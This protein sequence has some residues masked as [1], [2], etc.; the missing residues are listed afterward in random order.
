VS[1]GALAIALFLSIIGAVRAN[2]H[3]F[4]EIFA[5]NGDAID[6]LYQ[7]AIFIWIEGS[8]MTGAPPTELQCAD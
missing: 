5:E 3:S 2:K 8:E 1:L 7:F 6:D 4:C